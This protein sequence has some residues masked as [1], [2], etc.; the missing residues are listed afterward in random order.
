MTVN[1]GTDAENQKVR[2]ATQNSHPSA[3]SADHVILYHL[4]GTAQSGLF[5]E[6]P[7]GQKIGPLITGTPSS[8]G[9]GAMV[10][11][12]TF[13]ASNAAALLVDSNMDDTYP[14]Y[15]I[16]VRS[17][18]PATDDVDLYLQISIDGDASYISASDYRWALIPIYSSNFFAGQFDDDD[19]K[20]T[21]AFDLGSGTGESATIIIRLRNPRTANYKIID[22]ETTS[23]AAVPAFAKFT[24]GG[25]VETA[26]K[27]DAIQLLCSSGNITAVADLYGI[28]NS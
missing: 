18:V 12:N 14:E 3:P 1:I 15:E 27:L 17:I 5:V 24:G 16:R 13:N 7:S 11:L 28:K 20:I 9:A 2:F 21:V 23:Y 25:S 8:G 19:T 6:T 10:Y 4:T 22:F 26:S